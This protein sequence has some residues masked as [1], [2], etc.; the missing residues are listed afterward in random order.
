V[1]LGGPRWRELD[2][3]QTRP[4][5][6][7][8]GE[9]ELRGATAAPCLPAARKGKTPERVCLFRCRVIPYGDVC[10]VSAAASPHGEYS[11]VGLELGFCLTVCLALKL[12]QTGRS[13]RQGTL[14]K[15]K[16]QQR[17]TMELVSDRGLFATF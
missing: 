17:S 14:I 4:P 7:E 1:G 5:G 6:D 10:V 3:R 11:R 9:N 13:E 15:E 2:E 16:G 8:W 12:R